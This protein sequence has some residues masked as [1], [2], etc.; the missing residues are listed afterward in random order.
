MTEP[1]RGIRS[2]IRDVPTGD[3]RFDDNRI[4][5]MATE[6]S[7]MVNFV[8]ETYRRYVTAFVDVSKVWFPLFQELNRMETRRVH[9]AYRR[10]QQARRRRNRKR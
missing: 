4:A 3:L 8:S 2:V 6:W 9:T 7:R 5:V 10:K 1:I